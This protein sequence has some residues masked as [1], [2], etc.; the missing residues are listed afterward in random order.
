MR[1]KRVPVLPTDKEKDENEN[2]HVA[3][4]SQADSHKRSMNESWCSLAHVTDADLVTTPVLMQKLHSAVVT[5]QV[6]HEGPEPRAVNCVLENLDTCGLG[7][8]LLMG[9]AGS[10]IQ[11]LVDP[12]GERM[13]AEKSSECSHQSSGARENAV[14]KFESSAKTNDCVL[15]ERFGCQVNSEGIPPPWVV[16]RVAHVLSQS[17]KRDDDHNV[18]V[19]LRMR[20][21]RGVLTQAGGAV[22]PGTVC[23]K[24]AKLHPGRPQEPPWIAQTRTASARLRGARQASNGSET[25][26]RNLRELAWKPITRR[27]KEYTSK[28]SIP[29]NG[30]TPGFSECL[31]V[32]S[33]RATRRRDARL[34]VSARDS[35]TRSPDY[36]DEERCGGPFD[37]FVSKESSRD[38]SSGVPNPATVGR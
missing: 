11:T 15:P 8:V 21:C 2:M 9:D 28:F 19:R 22:D 24:M 31:G 17:E 6:S 32:S 27:G 1:M 7:E 10:A 4:R 37:V 25:Y 3:I 16:G 38:P 35:A 33:Q 5:R 14:Q 36:W 26:S 30:E 18:R 23:G 20:E 34:C 12:R 29:R 13:M